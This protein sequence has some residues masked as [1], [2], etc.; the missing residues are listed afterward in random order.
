[1]T[2][3]RTANSLACP[4]IH[5]CQ[6]YSYFVWS[7]STFP[8]NFSGEETYRQLADTPALSV[9][10]M[11]GEKVVVAVCCSVLQCVAAYCSVL[12]KVAVCCSVLQCVTVCCSVLQCDTV[13]CSVLHCAVVCCSVIHF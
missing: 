5:E 9:L 13:C 2:Q 12:Q 4:E 11:W 7:I 1:M 3:R 8:E 10:V 6:L